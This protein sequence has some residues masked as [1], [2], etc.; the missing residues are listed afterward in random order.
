VS[1]IFVQI[2]YGDIMKKLFLYVFLSF[3]LINPAFSEDTFPVY[4]NNSLDE[5]IHKFNWII[6]KVR[7]TDKSDIYYLLNNKRIIICIVSI[8]EDWIFTNCRKI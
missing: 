4:S 1:A 5:N 6:D 7:S 2:C 8:D 3:S